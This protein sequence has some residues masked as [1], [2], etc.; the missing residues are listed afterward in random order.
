MNWLESQSKT[1]SAQQQRFKTDRQV[2][3]VVLPQRVSDLLIYGSD[4]V[5]DQ[6]IK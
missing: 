2:W 4:C 3:C 5:Y 6:Y 1:E